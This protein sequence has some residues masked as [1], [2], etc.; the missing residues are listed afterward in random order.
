M[1][2]IYDMLTQDKTASESARLNAAQAVDMPVDRASR[3]LSLQSRTGLP[4]ELIDRNL[5]LVEKEAARADFNADQFRKNSPIFA[6]WVAENPNHWSA[7]KDDVENMGAIEWALTAFKGKL[8]EGSAE[9]RLNQIFARHQAGIATEAE[10]EE[11]ETLEAEIPGHDYGA[12]FWGEF[13]TEFGKQAPQMIGGMRQGLELGIPTA[14]GTATIA[15]AAGQAG[16]QIATPEE[17]VTVPAAFGLGL[18]SGF[19]SGAALWAEEQERGAA[20]REMSR[21]TDE[22]G[23]PL[24]VEVARAAS[25]WVGSVNALLEAG[26]LSAIAKNLPGVKQLRDSLVKDSVKHALKNPTFRRALTDFAKNTAEGVGTEVATEILQESV[27]MFAAEMAKAADPDDFEGLSAQEFGDTLAEIANK[28]FKATLIPGSVGPITQLG[29]DVKRARDAQTN[30]KVFEALGEKTSESKLRQRVPAKFREAVD[31]MR[32]K[33]AVET[34]SIPIERFRTY[35]QDQN[36]DPAQ[37]YQELG[38]TVQA[39]MEAEVAGTDVEIN[40]TDYAEKLAPS[41]HHAGLI[42]DLRLR[43]EDMTARE[44]QEWQQNAESIIEDL[45]GDDTQVD[46]APYQQ[47]FDDVVGQ[48]VSTN[49]ERGAAET[50]ATIM[51]NVFTSLAERTGGDAVAL[52][53]RYAPTIVGQ[54]PIQPGRFS[55]D[56]DPLIDRIRAG[57]I[58]TDDQVFGESLVS[59]LKSRGGLQDEGGELSARDVKKTFRGLVKK[60]GLSFDAAGEAAVEAGFIAESG[61]LLDAIDRELSG[62]A[63]RS[64]QNTDQKMLS[65]QSDLYELAREIERVGLDVAAVDND[66]IRE[67]V[68]GSQSFEQAPAPDSDAF[69]RWFE[70]SKVVDENG[71]PLVVYHGTMSDVEQFDTEVANPE[72]DWGAG[73]YLT[74]SLEDVEANYAGSGPDITNRI[75][76]LA[77]RI[78]A[79][80]GIE[81]DEARDI[82]KEQLTSNEGATMPVYVSMQKPFVV[83]GPEETIF[84][85]EIIEDENGDFVDEKGLLVDYIVNLRTVAELYEDGDPENY[86]DALWERGDVTASEIQELALTSESMGYFTDENGNFV[87]DEIIREAIELTGFDGIIDNT[88]NQKFGS[89]RRVGRAMEGMDENTVH[90]IVFD[91]RNVKSAIGNRGT[92]D[93]SDPRILFQ[94]KRGGITFGRDNRDILIRLG[95]ASDLST[96]LH[97]S[98]HLYL[99][100]L[101]DLAEAAGAPDQ[102]TQDYAAILKWLGVENRQGIGTDQHEHFA[103]GFEAYLMEGKAPSVELQ[104]AFA[105]FRAWLVGIYRRIIALDVDLN[106]DVRGVFDRLVATDDA[107][108]AAEESQNYIALFANAEEVGFSPEQ[109][110]LYRERVNAARQEAE[111]N[112]TQQMLAIQRREQ[113][114]WWADE[115][116]KMREVVEAE[117]HRMRVYQA[118][119]FLQKGKAPD[120][121]DVA[122][123]PGKLS[124]DWLVNQYGK[125]FLKR[126][127]KPWVYTVKGGLDPDEVALN[128]G[129]TSGDEM[130]QEMVNARNMERLIE[131]ETDARL[132]EKYPD[133]ML[134]GSMADQAMNAV[135]SEKRAQLLAAELRTLRRLARQ[136]RPAVRAADRQRRREE[137]Q[138]REANRGMLPTRDELKLVKAAAREMIGRA[139]IRDVNPNKYR[140]AESKASRLAFEYAG[141]KNYQKAYLEKRRQILNHELY[142]AAVAAKDETLKA[143]N[144]FAKFGKASIRERLGKAQDGRLEKIETILADLDLRK[145]SGKEIDRNKAKREMLAAI[146][147]GELVAPPATVAAL[148]RSKPVNW[149]EMS[150]D[151]FL[152]MRDIVRQLEKQASRESEMIIQGQKMRF[153]S[154]G[155]EIRTSVESVGEKVDVGLGQPTRG[156]KAK[157]SASEA[158]N[159]WLRPAGIARLLDGGDEMGPITRYVIVPLRRAYAEKLIP[160]ERKA[161]EDVAALY[162]KHFS[163]RELMA[164]NDREKYDVLGVELSKSDVLSIAFNWGNEENQ[165]A[166]LEGITQGR[167]AYSRSGVM[168]VFAKSMSKSDWEFVQ[169]VW[170][171]LD[172]YWGQISD[173]QKRRRGIS[174]K[175]VQAQP[176]TIRTKDGETVSLK[177]GYYP[178]KY[179]RR[180][181]TR[182]KQRE[183]EDYFEKIGNGFF[184]NANTRAGATHERVGAGGQVVRLGLGIIDQHLREIIR[185][186]AIGDE[187]NFVKRVLNHKEVRDVMRET[188]NDKALQA[189]NLWLQDA[190]IGE[191]PADGII[192]KGFAWT[193]VGFTKAK[194]GW[195]V[196]TTLLQ[197]T[198]FAQTWAVVGTESM[199]HGVGRFARNPLEAHRQIMALSP[200][201]KT[202]YDAGAWNKD[203]ADAQAMME[204]VVPTPMSQGMRAFSSTFFKPIAFAQM[205]VD[206]MTWLSALWKGQNKFGYEGQTLIDYADSVVEQAQTS[207]FFSDRSGLER[208]TSGFKNTRQSQFVRTWTTLISYM[209]AK[210]GIAYEKGVGFARKPSLK[211]AVNL[212]VDYIA[213]FT[214][215]AALAAVIYGKWPDEEDDEQIIPWLLKESAAS[216]V[217]GVPFV[218]EIPAAAFGGGNTPIGAL[219]KDIY[220]V[221]QQL[222]QGEVDKVLIKEL[223]NV[224]G[225]VFHYPSSQ[226]NRAIDAYW[227]ETEGEDVP[228]HE[229]LMGDRDR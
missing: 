207:G 171:Y 84:D 182:Q 221:G 139:D 159:T 117:V 226:I 160:M 136:D 196:L 127:P 54:E 9:V 213:L 114:K 60:D 165:K 199:A 61:E 148:E 89:E 66:A 113:K 103:R 202:R 133:P 119:S 108:K 129:F 177:G 85:Y 225:T 173:A 32:E 153:D 219:S 87:R 203:V 63:V 154:I 42:D 111:E 104:N 125:E 101:G 158:L 91:S 218:R 11:A 200:F 72:S 51:A 80:E 191:L 86:I 48:L 77:E 157:E 216:A 178:L 229:Y 13:I 7:V 90:Y 109:F 151:A 164:F 53:Q 95:K 150:V 44:A 208:G 121:S 45:S 99:E 180:H 163:K 190:A 36:I 118:L 39:Y 144:Y 25:Q 2:Q 170:D 123:T 58:P 1:G 46:T 142:R 65:L 8:K 62:Q 215:E 128:F 185:D 192:E 112:L 78:E 35:F 79:D 6:S 102:I 210:A 83:G 49:M 98:G 211:S 197:F 92:F 122:L 96:F 222:G 56:I 19:V 71:D 50:N 228:L 100:V 43:P 64:D 22:N 88:V 140:M 40:I 34:V 12:G 126:L 167:A 149:R 146:D 135:H 10:L 209:L 214:V 187:V 161:R 38:G 106:D 155:G 21:I 55:T 212:A 205:F 33:G 156:D 168:D 26:G 57:D 131:A 4:E 224:G 94:D 152:G 184:V 76:L 183:V 30:R 69:K 14:M 23:Q 204:T 179:D 145:I 93:P 176:F 120:G 17:I 141:K 59:F 28:T 132:K 3:V 137:R 70:G 41:E 74:N 107:I 188:G 223:N 166:L 186:V 20:F 130:I 24:D 16:P 162:N 195:N 198:G 18:S 193:R 201:L 217:S 27:S 134:D 147:A 5:D 73:I 175:K 206:E 138:A 82:A 189:L 174:P 105:R 143:R 227:R 194:L 68:L 169:E 67:A 172:S 47:I 29:V 81:M 52:Y 220:D 31:R 110:E 75:E 97:E 37:M 115:R 124:K 116:A 15:A 181:S